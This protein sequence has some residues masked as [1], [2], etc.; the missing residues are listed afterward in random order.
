MANS[1]RK[2]QAA[3]D[4]LSLAEL[5]RL[6]GLLHE[7]IESRAAEASTSAQT[8]TQGS[9]SADIVKERR[10]AGRTYQLRYIKCGTNGCHCATGRGHGP[11]WYALWS[12]KGRTRTAYIGKRLPQDQ[13]PEKPPATG[14]K[15]R[16]KRGGERSAADRP[17]A[18]PAPSA[19]A[20]IVP[21]LP[22]RSTSADAFNLLLKEVIAPMLKP[23]GLTRRRQGLTFYLERAANY[24]LLHFAKERTY[25]RRLVRFEIELGVFSE[26]I[27]RWERAA[28]ARKRPLIQDCHW[29]Q[30]MT[31]PGTDQVWRWTIE[32]GCKWE[33]L[34][35]EV[36][37]AAR[38]VAVPVLDRM[39]RDEAL[40]DE[41]LSEV[42]IP[43]PYPDVQL[44]IKLLKLL[45]TIG[46]VEQYEQ[47]REE[48]YRIAYDKSS[49]AADRME[50]RRWV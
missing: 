46:P 48:L 27:G 47:V 43:D 5:R 38:D 22:A 15:T 19:P 21:T 36:Q 49:R 50:A 3:L 34:A 40:R 42:K 14:E 12:E 41:W 45:K 23:S 7:L 8:A 26:S 17:G 13:P 20:L 33:T 2:A 1:L 6:D 32:R 44:L 35:A 4:D 39:I 10:A 9:A 29:R 37:T 18:S 16:R 25:S 11:Y 24:G 30:Y 31:R 28:F